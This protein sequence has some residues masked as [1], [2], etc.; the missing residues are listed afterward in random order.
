MSAPLAVQAE[1][2]MRSFSPL[3]W[4]RNSAEAICELVCGK[5][6]SKGIGDG[7][8]L[9]SHRSPQHSNDGGTFHG[10][11]SGRPLEGRSLADDGYKK[12]DGIKN[13]QDPHPKLPGM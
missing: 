9:L 8:W 12:C 4:S 1:A 5:V 7:C 13:R 3:N 11:Q 6:G 2:S 10:T